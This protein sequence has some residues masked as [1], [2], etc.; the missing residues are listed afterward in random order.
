[1]SAG[2]DRE[3]IDYLQSKEGRMKNRVDRLYLG[4]MSAFLAGVILAITAAGCSHPLVIGRTIGGWVCFVVGAL[5]FAIG[6]RKP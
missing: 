4:A 3:F 1:M 2:N 6:R 5:L